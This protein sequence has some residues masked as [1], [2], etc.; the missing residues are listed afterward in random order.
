M[1]VVVE[2][3]GSKRNTTQ[4]EDH[5]RRSSKITSQECCKTRKGAKP[6]GP[7][8]A[9]A[10]LV[11]LKSGQQATQVGKALMKLLGV[12]SPGR[13]LLNRISPLLRCTSAAT[14]HLKR[15]LK[16]RIRYLLLLMFG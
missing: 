1:S 14:E 3:F 9:V 6:A 15:W 4:Q 7:I 13:Y 16:K 8:F 2:W 11:A 12:K 5:A 10:D